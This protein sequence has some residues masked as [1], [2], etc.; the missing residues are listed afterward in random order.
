VN[1]QYWTIHERAAIRVSLT[2]CTIEANAD[3]LLACGLLLLCLLRSWPNQ[4]DDLEESMVYLRWE[5]NGLRM[6]ILS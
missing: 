2:T 1:G 5:G 4:E 6:N 3:L